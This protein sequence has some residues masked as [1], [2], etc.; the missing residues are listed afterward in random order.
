MNLYFVNLDESLFLS[1]K[2][3]D[4]INT[5]NNTTNLMIW[6]WLNIICHFWWLADKNY[7]SDNR[8]SEWSTTLSWASLLFTDSTWT[9]FTGSCRA[10]VS[11]SFSRG[12]RAVRGEAVGDLLPPL[13]GLLSHLDISRLTTPSR[14]L[15]DSNDISQCLNG[16]TLA[17]FASPPPF[18]ISVII[19]SL[20][21]DFCLPRLFSP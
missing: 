12:G 6:L 18:K 21:K 4:F 3:S 19:A 15:R 9:S 20:L 8:Y 16:C 10:V 5:R 11:G 13:V 7:E 14:I 1:C 17:R 2:K